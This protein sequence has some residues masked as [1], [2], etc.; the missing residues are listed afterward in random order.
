MIHSFNTTIL[1][2]L[3]SFAIIPSAISGIDQYTVKVTGRGESTV[4]TTIPNTIS[5]NLTIPISHPELGFRLV[6]IELSSEDGITGKNAP[7][8]FSIHLID[9]QK[10]QTGSNDSY[11]PVKIFYSEFPLIYGKDIEIF[12]SGAFSLAVQFNE[13]EHTAEQGAAANP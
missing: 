13:R 9:P 5:K 10:L 2:V 4:E 6:Q 12:K 3:I 11:I 8:I 1:I 7:D